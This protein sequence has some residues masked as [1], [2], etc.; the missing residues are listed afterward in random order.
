M[1]PSRHFGFS[2]RSPDGSVLFRLE[3]R[4]KLLTVDLLKWRLI[5]LTFPNLVHFESCLIFLHTATDSFVRK[6]YAG[7]IPKGYIAK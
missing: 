2:G 5:P 3:A 1:D 7:C 6:G 4:L